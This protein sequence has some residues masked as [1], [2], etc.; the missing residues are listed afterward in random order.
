LRSTRVGI[1]VKVEHFHEAGGPKRRERREL[2]VKTG[3]VIGVG[4]QQLFES[5]PRARPQAVFYE[6]DPSRP[7]DPERP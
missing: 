1:D 7:T 2:P 3:R 6:D 5:E 4:V